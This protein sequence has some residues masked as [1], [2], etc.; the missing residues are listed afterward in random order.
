M[1]LLKTP[2]MLTGDHKSLTI[3]PLQGDDISMFFISR[4]AV[5]LLAQAFYRLK[6]KTKVLSTDWMLV[7]Y[8]WSGRWTELLKDTRNPWKLEIAWIATLHA[9]FC[10]I[11][12]L[13]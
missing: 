12:E 1:L 11:L 3:D 9:I 4:V 2:K 5:N 8:S 6:E 10:F 13:P 7:Q